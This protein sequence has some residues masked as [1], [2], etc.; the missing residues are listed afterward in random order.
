MKY[1][2]PVSITYIYNTPKIQHLCSL[3]AVA[4]PECTKE[5]TF[6]CHL[7][8]TSEVLNNYKAT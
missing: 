6:L 5:D 4:R 8:I 3:Q 2:K 1:I 7:L